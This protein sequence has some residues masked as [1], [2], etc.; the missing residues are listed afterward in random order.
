MFALKNSTSTIKFDRSN[1]VLTSVDY[2]PIIAS[3]STAKGIGQVGERLIN[4]TLDTRHVSILGFIKAKSADDMRA[5]KTALFRMCD[6][7]HEFQILP[8]AVTALTC[9]ATDSVKFTASKITNNDRVAQF[10]IDAFCPDPLFSD[11][12]ARYRKIAEWVSNFIWPLSIPEDGFTF[13][14][15]SEN[16][17][18]TLTNKGDVETGL[19]IRFYA[20]ATVSTPVLTNV[21]TGE[22]IKLNRTFA[23]GETVVVNTNYG[24]EGVTSI[25]GGT[26]TDVINDFGLD[27]TFLQVEPGETRLHFTAATN[28]SS[29][30]VTIYYFQK[31]L[32]V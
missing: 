31:F 16:L 27:S 21:E 25:I 13:A 23:P 26:V 5:K 12:A 8:D 19:L 20:D 22:Y 32:G 15:R 10:V 30:I 18:A 3:H 11:A 14:N 4:T 9:Y 1:Y 6:P 29:M 17:I 2:G 28:A 24:Q 7:R